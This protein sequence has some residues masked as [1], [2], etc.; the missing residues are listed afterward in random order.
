MKTVVWP[1]LSQLFPLNLFNKDP[2][3]VNCV[4]LFEQIPAELGLGSSELLVEILLFLKHF[5]FL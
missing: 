4:E 1:P 5:T 3:F 2:V